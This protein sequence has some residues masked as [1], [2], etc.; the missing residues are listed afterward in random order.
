METAVLRI[1]N[2][3][4]PVSEAPKIAVNSLTVIL[5]KFDVDLVPKIVPEAKTGLSATYIGYNYL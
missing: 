1:K 3:G 4:A 5:F 2:I